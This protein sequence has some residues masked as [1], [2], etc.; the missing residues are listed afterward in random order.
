MLFLP[1]MEQLKINIKQ[2][3]FEQKQA[4]ELFAHLQD[5]IMRSVSKPPFSIA[6]Q[7]FDLDD[8]SLVDTNLTVI[9]DL[10]YYFTI[11]QTQLALF[12][13]HQESV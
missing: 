9:S 5:Q 10:S 7:D 3:C 1:T 11:P 6:E 12:I 8:F 2:I 13:L 4:S